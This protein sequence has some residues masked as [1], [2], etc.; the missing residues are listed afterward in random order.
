M[1]DLP[2]GKHS[3][4]I[5][6]LDN[7]GNAISASKSFWLDTVA[8]NVTFDPSGTLGLN[9]WHISSINLTASANDE[10]SG[11]DIFEYSVRQQHMGELHHTFDSY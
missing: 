11:L 8:P 5:R 4:D 7:A 1:L 9:N 3:V 2:D 6:A 10:T